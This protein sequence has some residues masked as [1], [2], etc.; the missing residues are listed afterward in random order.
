MKFVCELDLGVL[1]LFLLLIKGLEGVT[2]AFRDEKIGLA[3]ADL[4]PA[5][6]SLSI[7]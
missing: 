4:F 3:E 2:L 1:R 7:G 6:S 5:L